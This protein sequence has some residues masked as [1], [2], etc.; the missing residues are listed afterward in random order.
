VEAFAGL[1]IIFLWDPAPPL[2]MPHRVLGLPKLPQGSTRS[3]QKRDWPFKT[4]STA[5]TNLST[6]EPRQRTCLQMP[7]VSSWFLTVS[8]PCPARVLRLSIPV[9]SRILLLERLADIECVGPGICTD[10]KK[11]HPAF[12]LCP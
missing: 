8:N 6:S 7:S 9:E 10:E 11:R 4:S 3:R 1:L 12:A 5:S 2:Y